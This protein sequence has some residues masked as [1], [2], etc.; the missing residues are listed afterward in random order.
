MHS[1]NKHII[2]RKDTSAISCLM[3]FLCLPKC[4]S[5]LSTE[6]N[7]EKSQLSAH[8]Q[9]HKHTNPQVQHI[10]IHW[11]MPTLAQRPKPARSS[12]ASFF[13]FPRSLKSSLGVKL[14]T[15]TMGTGSWL[16]SYLLPSHHKQLLTASLQLQEFCQ[17]NQIVDYT[18]TAARLSLPS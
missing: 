8:P 16:F 4:T 5:T 3:L 7:H 18:T 9:I 2:N 17:R 15:V 14:L 12:C 10:N 11:E 6:G 1:R 13:V